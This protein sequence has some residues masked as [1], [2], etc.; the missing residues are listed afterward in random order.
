M[1]LL[2]STAIA[3]TA[4]LV[5][6]GPA[7]DLMAAPK[8]SNPRVTITFADDAAHNIK[9]DGGGDYVDG[10]GGVGAYIDRTT[11]VLNFGTSSGNTTTGRELQFDFGDCIAGCIANGEPL[12]IG[13]PYPS[14][15]ARAII[16]AG[17][18]TADGIKLPGGLLGMSV[19]STLWSGVKLNIPLDSDPAYWTLCM[20]FQN[21]D[22]FCAISAQST[23]ARI[24]RSAPDVWTITATVDDN[25]V[26]EL[27]NEVGGGRNRTIHFEGTYSMPF[28]FTVQCVNSNCS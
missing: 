23:P 6:A 27:F 15:Y 12:P 10:S 5:A 16:Q 3:L 13:A 14:G 25:D 18:R 9:S 22:G 7:I 26:G 21:T 19:G 11:G 4:A 20:V 28:S 8:P 17:V 1:R 24:V 2:I